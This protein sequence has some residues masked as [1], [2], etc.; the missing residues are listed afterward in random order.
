MSPS[1]IR[2]ALPDDAGAICAIYNH[3]IATTTISFEEDPVADADMAQRI[4]DVDKAGLPW[5]VME[6]DGRIVGYAYATRW[7]VR[8]AY[9]GSVESSIYLDQSC[10][11]RGLGLALYRVLLDAL[12]ERGLHRAIGGIAQPNAA[13][14]GLHEKLGFR[15]VAHF[16][17]VGRKFGR[18]LDV[19]YWELGLD[20]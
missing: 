14:V 17:E 18:W 7:R 19:G 16:T 9:R 13:S 5:L 4:A 12:R 20:A 6:I 10:A 15:K 8:P 11:G 1:T 3:Y 2:P